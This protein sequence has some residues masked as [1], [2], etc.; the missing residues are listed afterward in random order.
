MAT[1]GVVRCGY[2]PP[3]HGHITTT[4][5]VDSV[6]FTVVSGFPKGKAQA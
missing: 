5:T 6:V 3:S 4:L 2:S 1:M